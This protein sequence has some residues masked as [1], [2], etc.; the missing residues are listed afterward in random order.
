[1]PS[2]PWPNLKAAVTRTAYDGTDCGKNEA[3]DIETAIRLYTKESAEICGFESLGMLVPGYSA[4]FAVLSE[5]IFEMD[6]YDL[7]KVQVIETYINGSLAY[8]G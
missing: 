8:S 2:D 5:D 1:M 6:P 4:S 3:V 7:D